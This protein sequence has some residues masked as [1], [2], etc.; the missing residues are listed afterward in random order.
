MVSL[1]PSQPDSKSVSLSR[2]STL[3]PSPASL[4]IC[5][6]WGSGALSHI[7]TTH[8]NVRVTQPFSFCHYR[9]SN[10]EWPVASADCGEATQTKPEAHTRGPCTLLYRAYIMTYGA[11]RQYRTRASTHAHDS[12]KRGFSA[13]LSNYKY[14]R[15]IAPL[16][17]F[18]L[19][20]VLCAHNITV[21][22]PMDYGY[23][24]ICTHCVCFVLFFVPPEKITYTSPYKG[25][26]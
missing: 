6:L 21:Y 10:G 20:C 24:S 1:P 16:F 22:M 2:L 25:P 18:L 17:C 13:H 5:L 26:L 4:T 19:R 11:A 15:Y 23:A 12:S 14:T 3:E 7:V 9:F 8:I